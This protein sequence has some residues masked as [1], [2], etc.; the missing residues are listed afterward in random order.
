MAKSVPGQVKDGGE[1]E[2]ERSEDW[3][4]QT[5]QLLNSCLLTRISKLK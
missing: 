2:S 4:V 5:D 3:Q 1:Q